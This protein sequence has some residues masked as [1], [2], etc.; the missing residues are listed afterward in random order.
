VTFHPV[1]DSEQRVLWGVHPDDI[2][3]IE[4]LMMCLFVSTL[5]RTILPGAG[6]LII[7]AIAH[8][9]SESFALS[10]ELAPQIP[11]LICLTILIGYTSL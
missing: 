11:V 8:P 4:L 7:G 6:I 9:A 1:V 5:I 3:D 10:M 2:N